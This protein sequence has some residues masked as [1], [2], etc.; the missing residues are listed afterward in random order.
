M[1]KDTHRVKFIVDT[2]CKNKS[3]YLV[4]NTSSLAS[5]DATKGLKMVYDKELGAYTLTKM[6][7]KDTLVEYKVCS[8]KNWKNV[9][10]GMFKE[11]LANH[12]IIAKKGAVSNIVVYNY[13]E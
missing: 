1:N 6:I 11:E 12:T 10:K 2:K 4:G 8:G 7:L 5:W 9:E 13:A 3:L